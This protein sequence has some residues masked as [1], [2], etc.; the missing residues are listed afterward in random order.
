M[1]QYGIKKGLK[2]FGMDGAKAVI[3]EMRQLEESKA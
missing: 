3:A 2:E 1:T